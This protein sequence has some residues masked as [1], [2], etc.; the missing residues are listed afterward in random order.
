MKRPAAAAA[1]RRDAVHDL[2]PRSRAGAVRSHPPRVSEPS[3]PAPTF[4]GSARPAN[5][6]LRRSVPDPV[7]GRVEVPPGPLRERPRAH[8]SR[9]RTAAEAAGGGATWLPAAVDTAFSHAS[10]GRDAIEALAARGVDGRRKARRIGEERGS[11]M[12][13]FTG[14]AA[15]KL[16]VGRRLA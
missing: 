14:C 5:H 16:P 9:R 3:R 8:P 11:C 6:A 15:D 1:G 2:G 13:I 10:R 12:N 7:R 4:P